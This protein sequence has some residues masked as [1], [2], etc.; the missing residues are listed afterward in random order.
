[1]YKYQ[2]SRQECGTLW[3]LPEGNLNGFVLTCPI[4]IKGRGIFVSQTKRK[5]QKLKSDTTE[6]MTI[7]VPS[8]DA[9]NI[10][11]VNIKINE[12]SKRL[13]INIIDKKIESTGKDIVC[14]I[15]YKLI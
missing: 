13:P 4:C 3:T 11:D 12:L 1:M 15:K 10:E 8:K 14:K 6:E 7:I 5:M 2:C 9:K